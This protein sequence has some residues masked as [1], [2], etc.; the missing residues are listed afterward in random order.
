MRLIPFMLMAAL[1]RAIASSR[2]SSSS[3]GSAAA[4]CRGRPLHYTDRTKAAARRAP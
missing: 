1:L 2:C 4:T 3:C